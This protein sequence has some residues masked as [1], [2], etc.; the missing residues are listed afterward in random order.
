M[1]E[2]DGTCMPCPR[3]RIADPDKSNCIMPVCDGAELGFKLGPDGQ[4]QKCPDYDRS[5]SS[6]FSCDKIYCDD[7]E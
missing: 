3:Y 5:V 6:K 7:R 2:F 4:C 1:I